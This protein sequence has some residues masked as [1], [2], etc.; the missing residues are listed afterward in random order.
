MEK[1]FLQEVIIAKLN[2]LV[3]EVGEFNYNKNFTPT[4]I[5]A[6]RASEALRAVSA[7][8]SMQQN[9]NEGSGKEKAVEL[10]EK[11]SQNVEQM[12]KMQTF[13][14]N[15]TANVTR[16]KQQGGPKTPE[17]HGIM[18]SWN[19]HGGEEGKNWVTTELRK[20]HEENLRTKKNLR[21]AGGAG[22]N[23]GMGIFDTS[24]MSTTKQRIHK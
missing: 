11:K 9:T 3:M 18:Q 23:K 13:F 21:D 4:D 1:K 8:D 7:G 15:N 5:V 16:I 10:A 24:I 19:L 14:S 2:N 22:K 12:K 20:F 6:R 17:E